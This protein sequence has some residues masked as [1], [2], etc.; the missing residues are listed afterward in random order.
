MVLAAAGAGF[1]GDVLQLIANSG[2]VAKAVLLVLLGFSVLSWAVILERHRSLLRAERDSVAFLRDLHREKRLV[3][4]LHRSDRY[5]GSPLSRLFVAG[6]RELTSAVTDSLARRANPSP[7]DDALDRILERVQRRLD[8][9]AAAEADGLDRNLGILATTGSVTPFIGLFGTV[10]GIMNA[11]QGIGVTGSANL[12]AVAPGI[13]EALITTA[14]GLAAAIPAVIAY[15]LL[16]ARARRLGARI[17]R[18]VLE[19]AGIAE[20]QIDAGRSA[21]PAAE[22]G[23]IRV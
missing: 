13:S 12:A 11:F 23:K 6:F 21:A 3:D 17:E 15:N 1:N 7:P 20:S 8:E 4:L 19:F 14:A 5:A 9:A 16:N 10:W 22:A 18:F 2:A